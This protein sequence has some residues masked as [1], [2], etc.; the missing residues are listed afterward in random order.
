MEY[1]VSNIPINTLY[2]FADNKYI[3]ALMLNET[4]NGNYYKEEP[5]RFTEVYEIRGPEFMSRIAS[6]LFVDNPNVY[7]YNK[8]FAIR[9]LDSN[10]TFSFEVTMP[11]EEANLDEINKVRDTIA[12][13]HNRNR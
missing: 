11:L 13:E 3:I 9:D 4:R 2:K 1:N 12:S 6:G 8:G 5:R 10:D 7:D